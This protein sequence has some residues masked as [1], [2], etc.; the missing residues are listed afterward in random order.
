M[1]IEQSSIVDQFELITRLKA[2]S[3][4]LFP[5]DTLPALGACPENAF[6]LWEIKQRPANKPLILMGASPNE[7]FELIASCALDDAWFMASRYWP[8]ELTL[9]LPASGE[10][11]DLLNPGN[12]NIGL[13]VPACS[14]TNQLLQESGPLAT[15]SANLSGA[16]SSRNAVEASIAF[17]G[18]P[19]LGPLPWP[20]SSGMASTVISWQDVGRWQLLRKGAVIPNLIFNS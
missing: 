16:S 12:S 11:V 17:P 13:R 9:V 15:T 5:T 10:I 19:L 1:N 8:G 20:N 14:V 18:V 2:G 4:G 3:A 7:L 6:Y